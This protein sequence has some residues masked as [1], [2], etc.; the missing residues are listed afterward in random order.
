M[1]I[2]F[3]LFATL[4]GSPFTNTPY[5]INVQI[6]PKEQIERIAPDPFATKP[7]NIYIDDG[8]T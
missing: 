4:R 3:A 8:S 1:P 6:L 7:K 5:D 2:L